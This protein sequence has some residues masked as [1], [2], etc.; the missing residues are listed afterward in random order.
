MNLKQSIMLLTLSLL[1]CQIATAA[2]PHS[3]HNSLPPGLEKKAERGQALPPGWKKKLHLGEVL[4]QDIFEHAII[5]S[6]P[7]KLGE[8]SIR[9]ED[10]LL[11]IHQRTRKIID[12]L[13]KPKLP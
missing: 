6:P 5:L 2:P 9:I 3:K 10:E 11:K 12:I 8:I 13:P 4:P 7:D 1:A